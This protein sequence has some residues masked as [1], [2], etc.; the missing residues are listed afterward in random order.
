MGLRVP[1]GRGVGGIRGV[2]HYDEHLVLEPLGVVRCL[3]DTEGDGLV[4]LVRMQAGASDDCEGAFR[5]AVL[6]ELRSQTLG[7]RFS[8]GNYGEHVLL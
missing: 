5:G 7:G 1:G 3:D 2:V 4:L 6:E 8:L